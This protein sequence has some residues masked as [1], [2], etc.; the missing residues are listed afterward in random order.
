MGPNPCRPSPEWQGGRTVTYFVAALP[1][2]RRVRLLLL[3][4][5][6]VHVTHRQAAQVHRRVAQ[7]LAPRLV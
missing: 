4:R 7:H 5:P 2:S 6:R 1:D 3:C